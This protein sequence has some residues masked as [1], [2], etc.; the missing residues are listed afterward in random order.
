LHEVL[1]PNGKLE[2]QTSSLSVGQPEQTT[3][4]DEQQGAGAEEGPLKRWG[5]PNRVKE[6]ERAE[7]QC[8]DRHQTAA[9]H[10]REPGQPR[11][12]R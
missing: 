2:R 12:G 5:V 6:T 1:F 10:R 9:S 7:T 8:E 11:G 4:P 3:A